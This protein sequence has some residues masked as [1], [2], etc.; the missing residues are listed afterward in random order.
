[1]SGSPLPHSESDTPEYRLYDFIGN[2]NRAGQLNGGDISLVVGEETEHKEPLSLTD[3]DMVQGRPNCDESCGG[4]GYP[5]PGPWTGG[6]R[7]Y[8]YTSDRQT[9]PANAVRPDSLVSPPLF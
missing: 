2:L 5:G 6:S 9:R 8:D 3:I 1:M 4:G 7:V